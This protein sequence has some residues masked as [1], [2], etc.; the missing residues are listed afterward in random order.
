[1]EKWGYTGSA[2]V[3]MALD[4]AIEQGK[5]PRATCGPGRLRRRVQPSGRGVSD[6]VIERDDFGGVPSDFGWCAKTNKND[7]SRRRV[8]PWARRPQDPAGS[9]FCSSRHHRVG[10]GWSGSGRC[11]VDAWLSRLALGKARFRDE[12]GRQP[13]RPDD[14]LEGGRR[15]AAWCCSTAP[16][17]R[18]ARG[19]G[20]C[21]PFRAT[22]E[23]SSRTFPA[24]GRAT[25]A[26]D[27]S[28]STRCWP[29]SKR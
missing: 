8:G 7:S 11:K 9:A 14:G 23:W 28:G 10:A 24:T 22:T 27:R 16:A 17:T 4:D 12:P 18:P 19:R 13:R 20:W 3:P 1:M 21:A 5:I 29:A 25:P 15:A 6:A 26:R 2:C